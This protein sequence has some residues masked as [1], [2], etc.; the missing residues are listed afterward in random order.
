MN[1]S[2]PSYAPMLKKA[3]KTVTLTGAAGAGATGTVA[4]F[5]ISGRVVVDRFVG[6]VVTGLESAGG[7]NVS[8]GTPTKPTVWQTATPATGWITN[9]WTRSTGVSRTD[10]DTLTGNTQDPTM[11]DVI[12]TIDTAAVTAG[13]IV[14]DIWYYP[15]TSNGG[16]VAA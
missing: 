12:V 1:I 13:Q 10:T 8:I 15:A 6:F 9:D 3:Q 4:V 7:G 5:T 11:E 14:F 16:F 2:A